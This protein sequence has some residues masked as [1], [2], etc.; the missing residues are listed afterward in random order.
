M[1]ELCAIQL[2]VASESDYATYMSKTPG[3]AAH[4]KET[5]VTKEPALV[6]LL[7]VVTLLTADVGEKYLEYMLAG[8][9]MDRYYT[10]VMW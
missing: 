8:R 10:V 6:Q 9:Q 5:T 3:W 1:K 2:N 7:K 4:Q